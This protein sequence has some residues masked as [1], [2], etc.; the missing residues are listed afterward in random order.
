MKVDLLFTVTSRGPEQRQ[1]QRNLHS[2]TCRI[3]S[4]SRSSGLFG[5]CWCLVFFLQET[6]NICCWRN[7]RWW[8][9]LTCNRPVYSVF[10]L[11][12][13][14]SLCGCE[15]RY[16]SDVWGSPP[17]RSGI[18]NVPPN[19][20][21]PYPCEGVCVA[22]DSVNCVVLSTEAILVV[23]SKMSKSVHDRELVSCGALEDCGVIVRPLMCC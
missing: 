13:L 20:S 8:C 2:F 5:C 3:G 21:L 14:H 6:T 19:K 10:Y 23:K 15:L 17:G 16:R 12:D 18:S 11:L 22:V 7:R 9:P 4:S 1:Q